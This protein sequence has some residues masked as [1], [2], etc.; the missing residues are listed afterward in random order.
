M[1]T[2]ASRCWRVVRLLL[3]VLVV[4]GAGLSRPAAAE[5]AECRFILGFKILHDLIP[6]KVG[7]C[8]EN[9]HHNPLN[10]D[11]LQRSTGGL[12][13]WR[14]ADNFTAFTDGYRTW[15]NGPRG[16]Q[17]RLN[18]ERFA[19][20]TD[21]AA[22]ARPAPGAPSAP[23]PSSV[24]CA[25][26]PDSAVK[27]TDVDIV[28]FRLV[29]SPTRPETA[30]LAVTI[31]NNCAEPR[32]INYTARVY[33]D[34]AGP[35]VAVGRP[36]FKTG[37]EFAPHQ[38]REYLYGWC[39]TEGACPR[40]NPGQRVVFRT[41]WVKVGSDE[42]HCLN[43]GASRCLKTDPWLRSAV[44]DLLT[45]PAGVMLLRRA[46]EFGVTVQR[47]ETPAD[48]AAFY[49]RR[50][51]GIVLARDLDYLSEFERAAV[52][53]HELRHAVDDADAKLGTTSDDCFKAERRAFQEESDIW[54][55][56]WRD[57]LP[58]T[59]DP[60]TDTLNRIAAHVKDDPEGFTAALLKVY[61]KNCG[62]RG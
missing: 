50:T 24:A 3:V 6:D 56:L 11:A 46:A 23:N 36:F 9:E 13:V 38:E 58:P 48:A 39:D 27:G 42:P 41:N 10:G 34:E 32:R 22:A 21:A 4:A 1:T 55:A 7:E 43:V 31:R 59:S 15:V 35:P 44:E 28:R 19:W 12:L 62:A 2:A 37:D 51:K 60:I 8:T 16:L 49:S 25:S 29:P 14:K 17:Q 20:E 40:I 26:K 53:A 18:T 45:L 54:R 5:A 33:A 30:N 57:R 47:G 61:G 52:L